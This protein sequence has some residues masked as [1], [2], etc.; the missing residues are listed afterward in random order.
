MSKSKTLS[1]LS[2]LKQIIK[3]QEKII[4]KQESER[5]QVHAL[6]I[7]YTEKSIEGWSWYGKYYRAYKNL[8]ETIREMKALDNEFLEELEQV[9]RIKN[10]GSNE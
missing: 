4:K 3:I 6:W 2:D 8:I 10:G 1:I 9:L 7:H 5:K